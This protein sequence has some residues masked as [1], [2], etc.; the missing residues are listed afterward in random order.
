LSCCTKNGTPEYVMNV[1]VFPLNRRFQM[2]RIA[3]L[4]DVVIVY[5]DLIF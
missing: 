1:Q 2:F 3:R 4:P 5:V